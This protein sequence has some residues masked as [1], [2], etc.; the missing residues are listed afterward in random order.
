M[1][2]ETDIALTGRQLTTPFTTQPLPPG[3]KVFGIPAEEFG[4]VAAVLTIFVLAPIALAFARLMWKRATSIGRM[5][6][7]DPRDAERMERLE[8]AVDAIA[9]EIERVGES[10]R[11][12]AKLLAEAQII[13]AMPALG[14]AQRPA[15]PLGPRTYEPLRARDESR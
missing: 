1:Q 4:P 10:Q 2:L 11:Y 9:I 8:Q 5:P 15:E 12:Q 13:P 7:K 3:E 14:A 6:A